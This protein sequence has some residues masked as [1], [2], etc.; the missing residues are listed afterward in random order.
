MHEGV[1][2][3]QVVPLLQTRPVLVIALLVEGHS[4]LFEYLQRDLG[5]DVNAHFLVKNI[6]VQVKV[7]IS[8]HPVRGC[9]ILDKVSLDQIDEVA[10]LRGKEWLVSGLIL[11]SKRETAK[12]RVTGRLKRGGGYMDSTC[13]TLVASSSVR[14]CWL[15]IIRIFFSFFKFLVSYGKE[16]PPLHLGVLSSHLVLLSACDMLTPSRSGVGGYGVELG[17][18]QMRRRCVG[19]GNSREKKTPQLA[20]HPL[21]CFASSLLVPLL[22]QIR[23]SRS[24][25]GARLRTYTTVL[26]NPNPNVVAITS[27]NRFARSVIKWVKTKA[28]WVVLLEVALFV[29]ITSAVLLY[30]ERELEN[31]SED[32][33]RGILTKCNASKVDGVSAIATALQQVR[34]DGGRGAKAREVAL[35]LHRCNRRS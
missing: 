11:R 32:M 9:L 18:N 34:G 22:T 6:R 29:M 24:S 13:R 21:A 12:G 10:K 7:S 8:K 1:D 5:V 27:T 26:V 15:T 20:F 14:L 30:L 28:L 35:T 3:V 31:E 2:D 17:S 4:I 16:S 25:M 33:L 19:R 23:P